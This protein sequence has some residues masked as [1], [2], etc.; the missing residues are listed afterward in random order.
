MAAATGRGVIGMTVGT[1]ASLSCLPLAFVDLDDD[2]VAGVGVLLRAHETRQHVRA[3]ATIAE[4][5]GRDLWHLVPHA[6]PP[7][8]TN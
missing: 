8:D 7:A 3:L 6:H 2:P 4:Q 5:I 1:R